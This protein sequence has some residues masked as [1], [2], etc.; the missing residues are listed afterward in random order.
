MGFAFNTAFRPS[1]PSPTPTVNTPSSGSSHAGQ[2]WGLFATQP[3]R[4]ILTSSVGSTSASGSLKDM[5]LSVFNPGST[6]LSLTPPPASKSLS[7]ASISSKEV[8]HTNSKAVP[9]TNCQQCTAGSSASANKSGSDKARASTDIAVR[10]STTTALSK[11]SYMTPAVSNAASHTDNASGS[12]TSI[13]ERLGG[14]PKSTG[15]TPGAEQP[16]NLNTLATNVNVNLN[17][18]SSAL[19][20][21]TKALVSSLSN[22]H[23]DR[24]LS[25][26]SSTLSAADGLLSS[27]RA[28]TDGVIRSSKGKAR[29]LS[30]QLGGIPERVDRRN[31]RAKRRARELRE[32]GEE[33][34]RG[35]TVGVR[36]R[37]VRARRRAKELGGVVVDVG[38]EVWNSYEKAQGDWEGVF[39]GAGSGGKGEA[40]G[41]GKEGAVGMKKDGRGNKKEEKE[42]V[43]PPAEARGCWKDKLSVRRK[44]RKGLDYL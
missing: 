18:V 24:R 4:S 32:R 9:A 29:A 12:G 19:D 17:A 43:K 2:L 30:T 44:M 11:V 31:R 27:L 39:A 23:A 1:T 22:V 8:S 7:I 34:V 14:L 37:T 21:T 10:S 28:Q 20:A 38:T 6:S 33:I 42:N 26:L 35:V 40:Q 41:K 13:V 15:S 36:E 3:N 5:A 25:A 16:L